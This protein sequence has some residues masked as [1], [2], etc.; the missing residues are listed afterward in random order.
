MSTAAD[1]EW[2]SSNLQWGSHAI[3]PFIFHITFYIVVITY[4][5]P[6]SCTRY[7][8][9]YGRINLSWS[10]MHF[11]QT[12]K[13]LSSRLQY[14]QRMVPERI[15]FL[16]HPPLLFLSLKSC[17]AHIIPAGI[18]KGNIRRELVTIEPRMNVAHGLHVA[19][20]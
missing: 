19:F 8:N 7:V 18:Q 17:R 3:V 10:Q 2:V 15:S 16:R 12:I 4:A 14:S 11:F 1:N 9:N 20:I 6:V 5:L 13:S